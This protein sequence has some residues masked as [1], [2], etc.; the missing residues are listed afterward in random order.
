MTA[1]PQSLWP[2]NHQMADIAVAYSAGTDCAHCTLSVS[3]N[4]PDDGLGDGDVG[5][6][7]EV[8]DDHHV[9]VRAERAGNGNG[10]VYTITITCV[11]GAG[12]SVQT[13]PVYV[14]HD[15]RSPNAGASFRIGTPV[16]FSGRF[17]DGSGLTHTAKWTFDTL[18]TS[19]T[20]TEPNGAKTGS[21]SGA[22]VFSEPGVYRVAMHLT[23]NLGN[24]AVVTN[25]GDREAILVVYDP[26]GG[27]VIG[28][29]SLPAPHAMTFGFN[30]KYGNAKNPKGEVQVTFGDGNDF[31]ASS[32]D[33]LTI[34]GARAQVGGFGKLNGDGPYHFILTMIDGQ[35]EGGGGVDRMRIR[36]W[37]KVTGAV[38][39]DTQPG[40]SDAADPA[41]PVAGTIVLQK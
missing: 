18:S 40:A 1:T 6:D 19:G 36:I 41:T 38:V 9:R 37:H 10:R 17:W 34:T 27:Y 16:G 22:Y 35:A 8:V 13:V 33:Y 24:T 11:N 21:V 31:D 4:E 7:V 12:T 15:I 29:G 5:S 3:S 28:G 39:Y 20:V 30:S 2:P 32:L 26:A 14:A 25:A 23:D